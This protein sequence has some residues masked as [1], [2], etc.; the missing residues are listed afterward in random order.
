MNLTPIPTKNWLGSSQH[1]CSFV[2]L[3]GNLL[4]RKSDNSMEPAVNPEPSL[5]NRVNLCEAARSATGYATAGARDYSALSRPLLEHSD[6]LESEPLILTDQH[7]HTLTFKATFPADGSKKHKTVLEAC[8]AEKGIER[9]LNSF[10][11]LLDGDEYEIGKGL[12]E[13]GKIE[14]WNLIQ[15][16]LKEFKSSGQVLSQQEVRFQVDF[17]KA[18]NRLANHVLQIRLLNSVKSINS[19]KPETVVSMISIS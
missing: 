1:C 17:I 3:S 16:K 2:V 5:A 14:T 10:L 13:P 8:L 4:R 6:L 19:Y 15:K 9:P 7:H 12:T 18:F 11:G